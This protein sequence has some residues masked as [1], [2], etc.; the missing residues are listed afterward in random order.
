MSLLSSGKEGA[1]RL[2]AVR[3]SLAKVIKETGSKQS[4][5]D[6]Y[7]ILVSNILEKLGRMQPAQ[8]FA[9]DTVM[10]AGRFSSETF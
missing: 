7:K 10:T 9:G 2:N 6:T 1:T 8:T 3:N 4:V 5:D